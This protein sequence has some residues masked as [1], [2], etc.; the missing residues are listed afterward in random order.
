MQN[1]YAIPFF[2][3]I[4]LQKKYSPMETLLK[5]KY[6]NYHFL[7]WLKD[8]KYLSSYKLKLLS[9]TTPRI[10]KLERTRF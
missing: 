4:D 3:L 5:S 6:L 1:V 7:A 9:R 2:N 8:S 10:V